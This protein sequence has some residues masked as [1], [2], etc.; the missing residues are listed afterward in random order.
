MA[1]VAHDK[2]SPVL[3]ERVTLV[4][5]ESAD[6]AVVVIPRTLDNTASF[7]VKGLSSERYLRVPARAMRLVGK[8]GPSRERV[9]HET[10]V[11]DVTKT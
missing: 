2:A 4:N 5:A 1:H 10:E 8:C 9:L 3:P 6:V 7:W 11:A